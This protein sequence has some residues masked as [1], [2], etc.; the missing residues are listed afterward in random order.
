MSEQL[1]PTSDRKTRFWK[2]QKNTYGLLPGIKGSCPG[3]TTG[4]GGCW[5]KAPGR[6]TCTCYV[7]N[8]LVAYKNIR[9]NL[10][11]NT[12]ILMGCDNADTMTTILSAEF[13][14]FHDAEMRHSDRT[15]D[16]AQ[17]FYRLHWSGD[18]FN[19]TY[20]QAI[21][22]A[23]KQFNDTRFWIYTR[24]FFAVPY[25]TDIPNLI[26]YL[27]LD[28]VNVQ[29]GLVCFEDNRAQNLQIS[30]MDPNPNFADHQARATS[31]FDARNQLRGLLGAPAKDT[32]WL[33]DMKLRACPVDAGRL[34]LEGGC[35]TCRKCFRD[36]HQPIWF[37][38]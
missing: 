2:T 27:S 23:V 31:I 20:A 21:A 26:V 18:I 14:R 28:P 38:A 1:K 5:F 37:E 32:D 25:L 16:P 29:P 36:D 17:L 19:E 12:R 4:P 15:G 33:R 34:N 6:K 22:N 13:Q 10:E 24:S 3:A 11:H 30:Y 7:S 35:P 8:L 9:G